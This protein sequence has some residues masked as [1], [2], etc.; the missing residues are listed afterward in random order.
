MFEGLMQ[1]MH[2]LVI[3]FIALLFFGPSKLGDLGKGLGDGIRHF[4][5]AMREGL[6]TG[7]P[8]S[9]GRKS[10]GTEIGSE[11]NEIQEWSLSPC[12]SRNGVSLPGKRASDEEALAFCYF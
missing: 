7:S 12:A 11:I 1:P 8:G 10:A 9:S 3:L 6:G 2:L 5:N 4:K